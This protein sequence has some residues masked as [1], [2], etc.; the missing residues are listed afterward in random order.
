[1][2]RGRNSQRTCDTAA[3]AASV[4]LAVTVF[5][6]TVMLFF[7][8]GRSASSFL[9]DS[10]FFWPLP[11]LLGCGR[12]PVGPRKASSLVSIFTTSSCAASAPSFIGFLRGG[13]SSGS[14]Q[15]RSVRKKSLQN[16]ECRRNRSK[17][18]S[19]SIQSSQSWGPKTRCVC[20]LCCTMV[21]WSLAIKVSELV[22]NF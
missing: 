19:S 15:A 9:P 5:A 14:A 13:M 20:L 3:R 6:A 4:G 2:E 21:L 17:S 7:S 18:Q 11:F 16:S 12:L 8:G 1:M 22:V 10:H